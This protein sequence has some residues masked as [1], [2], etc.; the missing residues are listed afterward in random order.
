MALPADPAPAE[1]QPDND[2][3]FSRLVEIDSKGDLKLIVGDDKV[4]FLVCSRA[5]SRSARPWEAMLYGPFV[6]KKPA[7]GQD[8]FVKLPEDDPAALHVVLVLVH[9][10]S[11][12]LPDVDLKLAFE[13]T[14][15]TN[16]YGMTRCLWP[17]AKDWLADLKPWQVEGTPPRFEAPPVQWLWLTQELGDLKGYTDAFQQLALQTDSDCKDPPTLTAENP[18]QD[19]GNASVAMW[20]DDTSE[21]GK[22]ILADLAGE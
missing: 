9:G 13:V 3:T 20:K 8:W 10:N 2:N 19:G 5:L 14:I 4:C 21:A 17:C 11:D 1:G 22:V 16:K 12:K 15:L 18:P 7:D 6:E